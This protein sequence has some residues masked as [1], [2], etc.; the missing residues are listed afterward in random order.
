MVPGT[1]RPSSTL[2]QEFGQALHAAR[3]ELLRTAGVTEEE[4]GSL[5]AREAGAP[6][7]DAARTEIQG[8]LARLDGREQA[9][10]DSIDAAVERLRAGIFRLC[11]A[12]RGEIPIE[13]LRAIPTARR[14]L[15]CQDA[16]EA[17]R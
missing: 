16:Q 17:H 1:R 4:L 2:I 11:E 6:V 7:E 15:T 8:I 13:R 12:W 10:L 9:E 14:C 3:I 5:G